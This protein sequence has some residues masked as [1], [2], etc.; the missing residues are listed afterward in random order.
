MFHITNP[1]IPDSKVVSELARVNRSFKSRGFHPASGAQDAGGPIPDTPEN[2]AKA[3]MQA[4]PKRKWRFFLQE[5][6]EG[7]RKRR[8]KSGG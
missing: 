6:Q 7:K 5:H 2:I 1:E 8:D 4:P 3:I